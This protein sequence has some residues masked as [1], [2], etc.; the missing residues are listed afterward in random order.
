MRG[1]S[2]RP[3]LTQGRDK[4]GLPEGFR[5]YDLRR[6]GNTLAANSGTKL[7]GPHSPG[8]APSR[9][10]SGRAALIAKGTV[11]PHRACEAS[12]LKRSRDI[13]G[14]VLALRGCWTRHRCRLEGLY[15]A[16]SGNGLRAVP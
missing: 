1:T 15:S 2:F 7:K 11:R 6:T 12:H 13:G 8:A 16:Q 9:T 14:G 10:P 5:F 3:Q 4:V